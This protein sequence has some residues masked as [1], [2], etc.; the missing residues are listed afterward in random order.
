MTAAIYAYAGNIA[1]ANATDGR[2]PSESDVAREVRKLRNRARA[3]TASPAEQR[4][5]AKDATRPE[6]PP[7]PTPASPPSTEQ[8]PEPIDLDEADS[9]APARLRP[10]D[11]E[12]PLTPFDPRA[13]EWK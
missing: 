10:W 7:L 3:G 5:V 13:E 1:A 12:G 8:D 2:K 9:V 4:V 11:A 6:R